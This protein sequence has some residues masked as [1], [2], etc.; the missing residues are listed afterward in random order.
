MVQL[1]RIAGQVTALD[2]APLRLKVQ[3]NSEEHTDVYRDGGFALQVRP[4]RYTL[5]IVDMLDQELLA[6]KSIEVSTVSIR[7]T[8]DLVKDRI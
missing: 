4:G 7:V 5:T 3:L 6:E 8:I 2:R 1:V